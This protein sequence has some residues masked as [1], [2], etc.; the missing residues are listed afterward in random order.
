MK[1]DLNLYTQKWTNEYTYPERVRTNT[2]F[3]LPRF[4]D[5]K[6]RLTFI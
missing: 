4:E 1:N 2:K 5:R 3:K 6:V